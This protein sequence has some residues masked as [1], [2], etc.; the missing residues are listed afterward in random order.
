MRLFAKSI[1]FVYFH[2]IGFV[3][4]HNDTIRLECMFENYCRLGAD[5]RFYP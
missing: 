5:K 1:E 4:F 3:Y 2:I